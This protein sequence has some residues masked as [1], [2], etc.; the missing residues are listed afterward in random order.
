MTIIV[1]MFTAEPHLKS[2]YNA[3]SYLRDNIYALS[4]LRFNELKLLIIQKFKKTIS[5][6]KNV[7]VSIYIRLYCLSLPIMLISNC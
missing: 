4:D 6:R 1:K 7:S 3:I 5:I 2:V